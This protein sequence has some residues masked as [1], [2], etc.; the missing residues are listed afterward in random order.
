MADTV[1]RQLSRARRAL[2]ITLKEAESATKI[3]SKNLQSIE[4]GHYDAIPE[5]VYLRGYV[6]AYAKYLDLDPVP[7]LETLQLEIGAITEPPRIR[8]RESR[9]LRATETGPALKTGVTVLIALV[10]LAGLVFGA[11]RLT[12]TRDPLPPIPPIDESTPSVEAVRD[13][14]PSASAVGT[15]PTQSIVDPQSIVDDFTLRISVRPETSSWLRVSVDG[16]VAYEGVL[17]GDQSREWLVTDSATIRVGRP[18]AV[19]ITKNGQ[20]VAIPPGSS[21]PEITLEP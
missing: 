21:T 11:I 17:I 10:V 15:P 4:D 19:E 13:Q 3:R 5:P 16:R 9:P 18:S 14:T 1:G 12:G 8:P 2:G 20:Q 6:I 7:L